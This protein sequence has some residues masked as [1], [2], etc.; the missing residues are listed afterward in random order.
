MKQK[1]KNNIEPH[2][3]IIHKTF[4]VNFI[5]YTAVPLNEPKS[6]EGLN[7][8]FWKQSWSKKAWI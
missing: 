7:Q 6:D 8:I 2:L 3:N 4:I 5:Q 1:N